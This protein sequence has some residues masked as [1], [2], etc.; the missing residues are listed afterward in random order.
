MPIEDTQSGKIS[1]FNANSEI[2]ADYN[3]E[4]EIY[5][6]DCFKSYTLFCTYRRTGSEIS[7]CFEAGK[8][9]TKG[10]KVYLYAL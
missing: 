1:G 5:S 9:L 6:N 8:A 3:S 10:Y 2:Y 4:L 7:T